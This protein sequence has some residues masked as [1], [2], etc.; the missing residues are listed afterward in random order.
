[1]EFSIGNGF[2][3]C[4]SECLS[5]VLIENRYDERDGHVELTLL[6]MSDGLIIFMSRIKQ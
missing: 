1:M 3:H 4:W 5:G 2:E 6:C